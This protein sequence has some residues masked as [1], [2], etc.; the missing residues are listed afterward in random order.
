MME[1]KMQKNYFFV[2]VTVFQFLLADAYAKQIYR[3]Y[4]IKS[5]ILLKY[6][7][8]GQYRPA[9]VYARYIVIRK[10]M[11]GRIES[12][13]LGSLGLIRLLPAGRVLHHSKTT[14]V[15]FNE[16]D[17]VTNSCIS[18]VRRHGGRLV[19]FEE[20]W[21]TYYPGEHDRALGILVVPDAVYAAYPKLY[22][23]L[24]KQEVELYRL[25]Y[26]TV[27]S[28][29]RMKKFLKLCGIQPL[30]LEADILF[31]GDAVSKD[32]TYRNKE[33]RMI[34]DIVK[35]YPQIQIVIKPH[36]FD[37]HA[38]KYS[39]V[40]GRNVSIL[41]KSRTQLPA[42]VLMCDSKVKAVVS[43]ASSAC[44]TLAGMYH[45]AGFI[46]GYRLYRLL[47][48]KV[49]GRVDNFAAVTENICVPQ[50]RQ[51]L[52]ERIGSSIRGTGAAASASGRE[53]WNLCGLTA[54]GR[55]EGGS[56]KPEV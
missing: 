38:H 9:R 7:Y 24:H 16:R 32:D 31:L 22:R 35:M 46:F 21:G 18:C 42:E 1:N 11:A 44:I 52:K 54:C 19:M 39:G 37:G 14:L 51:Q 30:P 55:S 10:H 23:Q 13:L 40:T 27:F 6:V 3:K 45:S 41:D 36:P 47:S 49:A 28:G 4:R 8:P 43:L 53:C 29:K 33:M 5:T 12:V 2:C 17:P 50:T 26:Q 20:G 56:G 15:Y 34:L 48:P 25:D